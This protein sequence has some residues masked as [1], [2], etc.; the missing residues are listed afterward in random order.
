[1]I[2]RRPETEEKRIARITDFFDQEEIY[3]VVFDLDA[4][5]LDTNRYYQ[6]HLL[7]AGNKFT[8]ALDFTK[9]PEEGIGRDVYNEA[10]EIY[11]KIK[12]PSNV[13]LLTLKAIQEYAKKIGRED[14]YNEKINSIIDT[15]DDHFRLFYHK[16]PEVFSDTPHI[17]D[18]VLRTG[19]EVYIHSIGDWSWTEIK[20]MKIE[21][22]YR[23]YRKKFL[24]NTIL[25]FYATDIN[26]KKDVNAWEHAAR[27]LGFSPFHSLIVGDNYESDI[28]PAIALSCRHIVHIDKT[29]Y[30]E[31]Q[32][33]KVVIVR[34]IG[35]IFDH[36]L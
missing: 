19:R 1:M 18:I 15:L 36:I 5:L 27:Y 14:L 4:T 7:S 34:G 22:A 13:N 10:M 9:Y 11:K 8:E 17:I 29:E 12:K 24:E 20:V 31:T 28:E 2:E 26:A 25:P 3:S 30:D 21:S 6:E 33:S 16:S 23:Q 35:E 32:S